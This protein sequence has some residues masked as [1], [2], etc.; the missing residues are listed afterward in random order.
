MSLEDN[1]KSNSFFG[2]FNSGD[3][4]RYVNSVTSASNVGTGV[5]VFKQKVL[6][7]LEFRTLL[8][9]KGISIAESISGD[10][11]EIGL[12]TDVVG[13]AD[14]TGWYTFYNSVSD[15]LS[16]LV[17]GQTLTFF[18][19]IVETNAVSLVL[20]DGITLD[21]NGFTYTLSSNDST[22]MFVKN[23]VGSIN[24]KFIN[25]GLYR[26]NATQT[27][28][29]Q[30][31]VFYLSF[32][33]RNDTYTLTFDNSFTISNDGC[34]IFYTDGVGGGGNVYGGFWIGGNETLGWSIDSSATFTN[35][36]F[37]GETIKNRAII[38]D[39]VIWNPSSISGNGTICYTNTKLI[40]CVIRGVDAVVLIEAE[41][42]SC[43]VLGGGIAVDCQTSKIYNSSIEGK[44]KITNPSESLTGS[45]VTNTSVYSSG[46]PALDSVGAVISNCYFQSVSGVAGT[47]SY[48]IIDNG[49]NLIANC[50]IR[51]EFANASA[52]GILVNTP[53]GQSKI[54]NNTINMRNAGSFCITTLDYLFTY[55]VYLSSNV[56]VGT[57]TLIDNTALVNIQ[58]NTPDLYGNIII[59]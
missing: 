20:K 46:Y 29:S 39:C 32:S 40:N 19:N 31:N 25:G 14:G 42:Y 21:L 1:N 55:N 11:V 58:S 13:I 24:V 37:F 4:G 59:G 9:A 51:N 17:S 53:N 44:L 57:T 47:K 8:E 28:A 2:V 41:M 48:T 36:V 22:N 56:G 5:G 6:Q 18:T 26:E 49:S 7:D 50:V 23:L 54:V 35:S 33:N 43:H 12:S 16:A 10:E 38:Q 3:A 52:I 27:I 30:G 45:I 34:S 15:G